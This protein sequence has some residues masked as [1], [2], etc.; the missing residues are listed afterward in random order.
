VQGCV[1]TG[2]PTPE[3]VSTP[4]ST[5]GCAPSR[6]KARTAGGKLVVANIKQG[7]KKSEA[8]LGNMQA[9]DEFKSLMVAVMMGD[10]AKIEEFQKKKAPEQRKK[11]EA[12]LRAV[13]EYHYKNFPVEGTDPEDDRNTPEHAKA[14]ILDYLHGVHDAMLEYERPVFESVWGPMRPLLMASGISAQRVNKKSEFIYKKV[15][16]KAKK[17]LFPQICGNEVTVDHIVEGMTKDQVKVILPEK[18]GE[19]KKGGEAEEVKEKYVEKITWTEFFEAFAKTDLYK[20][21]DPNIQLGKM[22]DLMT[23]TVKLCINTHEKI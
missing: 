9:I 20:N 16:K 7:D 23:K 4:P 21:T 2:A 15:V 5:M 6:R 18:K 22:A 8:I 3:T 1:T 19:E 13:W 10:T 17:E 12:V 11:M 14:A